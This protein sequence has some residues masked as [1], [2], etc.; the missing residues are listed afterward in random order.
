M[1][2]GGKM[3]IYENAYIVEQKDGGSISVADPT[4]EKKADLDIR[5]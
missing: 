2:V 5:P 1:V 4:A 3:G